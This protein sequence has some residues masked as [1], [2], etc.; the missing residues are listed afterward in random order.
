MNNQTI[1][2]ESSSEKKITFFRTLR[3]K[4]SKQLADTST[5]TF[6][7]IR[8]N[9]RLQ[10][11]LLYYKMKLY[12]SGL[13]VDESRMLFDAPGVLKDDLFI[14][15]IRAKNSG[16]SGILLEQRL[17]KLQRLL[18]QAIWSKDLLRTY[19]GNLRFEIKEMRKPIRKAK[20]YSGYVRSPSAVGTKKSAG[21]SRP[22]FETF[23]WTVESSIDYYYFLTVGELSGTP[24]DIPHPEEA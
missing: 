16:V 3:W 9:L 20:K 14:S 18:K 11:F 4:S 24:D 10:K 6:W 21:S 15:L 2:V 13:S 17:H 1:L 23:E 7:L 22:E 12:Y 19:E 5:E 8:T